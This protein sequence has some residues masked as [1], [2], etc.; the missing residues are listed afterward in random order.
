M[1]Q[2]QPRV[3]PLQGGGQPQGGEIGT[4]IAQVFGRVASRP[5]FDDGQIDTVLEINPLLC[6]HVITGKLGLRQPE[7]N[8]A[9]LFDRLR[10][11]S[12]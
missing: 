6:R 9:R 1:D 7:G 8:E 10:R 3:P 5:P 11:A 4:T 12:G 2:W